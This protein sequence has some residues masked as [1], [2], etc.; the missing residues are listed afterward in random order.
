M[1]IG[2]LRLRSLAGLRGLAALML[3]RSTQPPYL[4]SI[5]VLPNAAVASFAGQ[6]VQYKAYGTYNRGGGHPS[7]NQDI[8]N[9]VDWTSNT[10]AVATIDSTGLATITGAGT[11]SINENLTRIVST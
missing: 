10:V 1:T 9:Q 11:T 8:T 4:T 6:T 5:Q 2:T 3:V 7:Q